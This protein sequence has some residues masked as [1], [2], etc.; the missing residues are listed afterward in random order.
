M[1]APTAFET[2]MQMSTGYWLSRSLH[3]LAAL[4]VADAL[5]DATES[6]AALAR[7]VGADAGA[8]A[9]MLRLVASH[10]VFELREDGAV[11]HN[12]A[13]RML[14]S[15]HPRSL[16]AFVQMIGSSICWS[17]FGALEHS[18]RTGAPAVDQVAPEGLFGHFASHPE[19]ARIFDAA[20]TGKAH[21]QVA[22]VLGAYDFTPFARIADIGG[23]NGHLIRA[24][25]AASPSAR[26]VLFDLPHV[27]REQRAAERLTLQGGD[28]FRDALPQCDLYVL[29]EVIH[30]WADRESIAILR[31]VRS[32]APASA[33]LL[34]VENIVP[35]DS[36]PH[37]AKALDINML[38]TTGGRERT[39]GEYAAL[40]AAAGFRLDR[41]V[42]SPAVALIE[43]TPI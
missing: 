35:E 18:A 42:E 39:R 3:V 22:A 34:V 30:D 32:A 37:W 24:V 10:G 23:G 25:L 4:G 2:L 7:T 33:K 31:A 43:A 19:E 12:D 20:M 40:L 41:V 38:A 1:T 6:P 26:G 13:S 28:F 8:L 29:M 5:G 14:R 17:A 16:R 36:Q 11:A 21:G 15:D 27:V 9:R